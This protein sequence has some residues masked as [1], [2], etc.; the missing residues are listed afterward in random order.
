MNIKS[1]CFNVFFSAQPTVSEAADTLTQQPTADDTPVFETSTAENVQSENS[2]VAE[3]NAQTSSSSEQPVD[4]EQI[5]S[6]PVLDEAP[7]DVDTD[8]NK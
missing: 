1:I 8:S 2:A 6:Q 4:S 5:E 7:A 3:E